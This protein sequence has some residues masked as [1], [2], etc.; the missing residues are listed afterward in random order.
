MSSIRSS[1]L[2]ALTANNNASAKE[3]NDQQYPVLQSANT[4]ESYQQFSEV[5]V[6]LVIVAAFLSAGIVGMHRIIS[7]MPQLHVSDAAEL[8]QI[9]RQLFG[10][11]ATVFLTFL[12]RAFFSIVYAIANAPS[13]PDADP[14][15]P[16]CSSCNPVPYLMRLW[17]TLT[18]AFQL[19]V[20]LVSSPLAM[21]VALWGMTS[22]RTLQIMKAQWRRQQ[23]QQL[24]AL[25][26]T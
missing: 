24:H 11:V 2:Y 23:Q 15:C 18:P 17:I 6:L 20:E 9:R 22:R 16:T 4:A 19:V 26:P 3:Y 21:L 8:R 1:E 12:L 5:A 10:T 14:S 13:P 25:I 7:V